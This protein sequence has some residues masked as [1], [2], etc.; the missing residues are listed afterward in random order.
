MA[1]SFIKRAFKLAE[2]YPKISGTGFTTFFFTSCIVHSASIKPVLFNRAI[3]S[4][5][6][7]GTK[8]KQLKGPVKVEWPEVVKSIRDLIE[9]TTDTFGVVVGPSGTGKTY[10]TRAACR[11]GDPSWILYHE[12]F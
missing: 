10:A 5:L 1:L 12:I 4:T 9:S 7:S 2:Q 8:P 3:D 6:R 11:E